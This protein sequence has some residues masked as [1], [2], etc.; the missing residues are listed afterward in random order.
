[1]ANHVNYGVRFEQMND[2]A[3][4]KWKELTS[5]LV[6]EQY[7]YWMGDLWVYEG[8]PVNS[9]DVRE[10]SWTTEHVGPKWCYIQDFDEESFHGYS[11][12][13]EP[14]P[15]LEW[16]LSQ[17]A[18]LD[19]QMITTI[20]YEDEMPNFAGV[21]V[22][23]GDECID[24]YEDEHDEIMDRIFETH[25]NLKEKWDEENEDWK[26]EDAQ[27]E[28]QEILWEEISGHQMALVADTV[29]MI[30]NDQQENQGS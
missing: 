14:T 2:A 9:E 21:Y 27:E 26:D 1:M 24:G 22:Y 25:Q 16:I 17:L 6:E 30:K 19:P 18:P 28:F 13:S 7:E 12:W 23:E 15:A 29:E 8:G 5:R 20:T 10:Y 3:K 11:A 4:A